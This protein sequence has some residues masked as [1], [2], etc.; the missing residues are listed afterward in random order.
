MRT[1]IL[2]PAVLLLSA[3]GLATA[4]PAQAPRVERVAAL[5]ETKCR[6]EV[7][8]YISSIRFIR[9]AAGDKMGARIASG[10]VSEAD[11]ER[12]ASSQGPC[13]AA[14]ALRAKGAPR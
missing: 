10:Y 2:I 14:Q 13:A 3:T 9:E 6:R 1:L 8:E 4:Q 5:D 7:R 11:V 12:I